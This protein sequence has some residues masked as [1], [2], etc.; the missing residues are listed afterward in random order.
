MGLKRQLSAIDGGVSNEATKCPSS[1]T[2][3]SNAFIA[4][5]PERLT[6]IEESLSSRV[7]SEAVRPVQLKDG[8]AKRGKAV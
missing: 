3:S 7:K 2:D 1:R 6:G 4:R 8:A 5:V